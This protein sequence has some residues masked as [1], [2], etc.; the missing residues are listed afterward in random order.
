MRRLLLRFTSSRGI[1]LHVAGLGCNAAPGI[2][3]RHEL[4]MLARSSDP[5]I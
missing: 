1:A 5:G 2:V 3:R 4:R